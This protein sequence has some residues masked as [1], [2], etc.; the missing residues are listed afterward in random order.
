VCRLFIGADPALWEKATHSLRLHGLSTSIRIEAFFWRVLEEV[1]QRDGLI[2]NEL[3]TRLYDEVAQADRDA[4]NFASF[5]R[6]CCGR[7][8]ALQLAG[9]IPEDQAVPIRTLDAQAILERE[10]RQRLVAVDAG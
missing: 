2:L 8:L 1:A 9:E 7:Y 3:L 4:V 5:L 10:R 6:V